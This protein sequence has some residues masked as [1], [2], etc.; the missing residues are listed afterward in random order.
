MRHKMFDR[1]EPNEAQDFHKNANVSHTGMV[2]TQ[3]RQQLSNGTSSGPC[4]WRA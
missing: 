1:E 3:P 2:V 4:E